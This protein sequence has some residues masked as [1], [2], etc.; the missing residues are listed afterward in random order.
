VSADV[1]VALVC[2]VES[3]IISRRLIRLTGVV[4]APE[5]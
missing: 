5:I 3:A 2:N 4:S 1:D